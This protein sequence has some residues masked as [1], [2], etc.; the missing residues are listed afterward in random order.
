M[1]INKR[2]TVYIP[3][4]ILMDVKKKATKDKRSLSNMVCL[5]LQRFIKDGD[6]V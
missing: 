6:S 5:I 4:K 1:K 2:V 3:E